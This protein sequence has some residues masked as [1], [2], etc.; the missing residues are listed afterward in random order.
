[1]AGDAGPV[2]RCF[3]LDGALHSLAKLFVVTPERFARGLTAAAADL[4]AD[5]DAELARAILP[6]LTANLGR[7]P[8]APRHIHLV[9]PECTR[10]AGRCR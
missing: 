1:V 4:E 8:A 5:S 10:Q 3:D 7:G 2:L 6:A 9:T